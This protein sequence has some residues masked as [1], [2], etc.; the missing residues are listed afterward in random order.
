MLLI[1]INADIALF[2]RCLPHPHGNHT[3]LIYNP[4]QHVAFL[5]IPHRLTYYTCVQWGGIVEYGAGD[6]LVLII[7]HL[8]M[9]HQ[10]AN[11]VSAPSCWFIPVTS[12]HNL[13]ERGDSISPIRLQQQSEHD[14]GH[15]LL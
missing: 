5:T 4:D 2:C 14:I 6:L 12:C 15:Y 11:I 7:H 10:W 8:N 13:H 3:A 1:V 9:K